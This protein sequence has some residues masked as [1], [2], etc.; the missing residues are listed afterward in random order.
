MKLIRDKLATR[1]W[2]FLPQGKEFVRPVKDGHEHS[3]LLRRKLL[4]EVAEA[5]TANTPEE[6]LMELA[7]IQEVLF[8]IAHL[9]GIEWRQVEFVRQN[10]FADRGGFYSGTVW[11][12]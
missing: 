3:D 6:L 8:A 1:P 9:T 2:E 5:I 11:D 10:K 7:D 4:E 12:I